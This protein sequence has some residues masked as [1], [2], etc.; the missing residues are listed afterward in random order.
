MA[1]PK[2]LEHDLVL[3][4]E[5]EL[6]ESMRRIITQSSDFPCHVFVASGA[7]I[8]FVIR[9]QAAVLT[10]DKRYIDVHVGPLDL[11]L[12]LTQPFEDADIELDN[13]VHGNVL[14][15][16]QLDPES[17]N[18]VSIGIPTS[19]SCSSV[20]VPITKQSLDRVKL[21]TYQCSGFRADGERCSNRRRSANDGSISPV[22]CHHHEY[23][24]VAFD[25]FLKGIED[26]CVPVK[27]SW[28]IE[29]NTSSI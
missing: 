10:L 16:D 8:D 5:L 29:S 18:V 17:A 19:K 12:Q 7:S 22:W 15:E 4:F 21:G 13:I 20:A 3:K 25:N 24:R 23:Q 1:L 11:Q 28:W 9:T 2:K 26:D 6:E 27:P 14:N